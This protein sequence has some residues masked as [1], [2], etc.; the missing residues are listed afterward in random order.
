MKTIIYTY[1]LLISFFLYSDWK[2]P[3]NNIWKD[4][5]K[6]EISLHSFH[7]FSNLLVTLIPTDRVSSFVPTGKRFVSNLSSL[8][9]QQNLELVYYDELSFA[10]TSNNHRTLKKLSSNLK[11]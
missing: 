1:T 6:D 10:V 4:I 3:I 5:S 7:E 9:T 2:E 8:I 11:I